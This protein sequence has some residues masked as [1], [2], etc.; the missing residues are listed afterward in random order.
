MKLSNHTTSVLKN[1][2]TIN[3]NLVI[4]EGN[5]I[6]TMSAMKNIVA[7]ADVEETFPQ[8]VAIYDLNE[9]LA[10]MSLFTSPVLEFSENHV[11]ITEENN[12]SNSLKYFYSDP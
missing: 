2:A 10:S 5:T 8:E 12:T 9:F 6:T 4:K 3:Q 7:K 1:F 11:M